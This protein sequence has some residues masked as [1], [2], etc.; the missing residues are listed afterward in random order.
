MPATVMLMT[1]VVVHVFVGRI[2]VI[3]MVMTVRAVIVCMLNNGS[4]TRFM[5][6]ARVV[7]VRTASQHCVQRNCRRRQ[8]GDDAVK[9][10]LVA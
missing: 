9:Q 3:M 6:L 4:Q 5:R 1:A 2:V 10:G 8:D 7:V